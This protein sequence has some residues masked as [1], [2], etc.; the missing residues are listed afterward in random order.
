MW[1][2]SNPKTANMKWMTRYNAVDSGIF[3][4]RNMETFKELTG[5][6]QHA[7]LK[8]ENIDQESQITQLRENYAAK[9]LLSKANE[10]RQGIM[11]EI[12]VYR[13][14]ISDAEKMEL[15]RCLEKNKRAIKR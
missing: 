14:T 6:N 10:K 1:L 12:E 3:T 2:T 13:Q 11:Q 7:G 15:N 4:T 8:T 9:M 5:K